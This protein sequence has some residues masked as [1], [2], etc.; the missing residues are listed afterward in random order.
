MEKENAA[1]PVL[2]GL[3]IDHRGGRPVYAQI[4]DG[5][6]ALVYAGRLKSG[7]QLPTVRA[8]AEALD[9]NPNTAARAYRELER[10][11]VIS[12]RVGRG[13][14]IARVD[15]ADGKKAVQARLKELELELQARCVEMGLNEAQFLEYIRKG[16][17]GVK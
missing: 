4:T 13:S 14:F 16:H 1:D 17:G 9:I 2:A 11:G 5:I 7:L 3:K 6:K 15:G 10:D 12:S 8:L